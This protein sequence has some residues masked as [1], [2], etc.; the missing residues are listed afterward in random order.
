MYRIC[1]KK[2]GRIRQKF[3]RLRQSRSILKDRLRGAMTWNRKME[4]MSKTI[5]NVSWQDLHKIEQLLLQKEAQMQQL[6]VQHLNE[7]EKLQRKLLRRDETLRKI[8][9]N[10]V[11]PAKAK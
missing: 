1:E 3:H 11:K 6:R 9:L 7:I 10:K 5:N 8:L 4:A 2:L